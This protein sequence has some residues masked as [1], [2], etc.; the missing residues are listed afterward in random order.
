MEAMREVKKQEKREEKVNMFRKLF[1]YII[2]V[3]TEAAEIEMTRPVTTKRTRLVLN[4]EKH[5]MCFWTGSEWEN[6]Q[7]PKPIKDDVYIQ[8]REPLQVFVRYEIILRLTIHQS[9]FY[10]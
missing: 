1:K 2:G 4:R 10:K 3:N 8:N 7:L 9:T 6:R 5:E